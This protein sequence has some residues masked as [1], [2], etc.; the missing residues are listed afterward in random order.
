MHNYNTAKMIFIVLIYHTPKIYMIIY[1]TDDYLEPI[2]NHDHSETEDY[3]PNR[4]IPQGNSKKNISNFIT[5]D[6][7]I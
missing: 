4:L 5:I 1:S 3:I 7:I 2:C 6:N